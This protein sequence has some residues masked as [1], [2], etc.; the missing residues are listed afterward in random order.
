M[1]LAADAGITVLAAMLIVTAAMPTGAASFR[2]FTLTPFLC[3]RCIH[4]ARYPAASVS[5][6]KLL[7][8]RLVGG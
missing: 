1:L 7:R 3:R 8:S 5:K 6:P 4:R 2:I